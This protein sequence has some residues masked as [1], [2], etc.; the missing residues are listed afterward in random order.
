MS[1]SWITGVCV[2]QNRLEWTVLRRMKESWEISDQGSTPIPESDAPGEGVPLAVLK[3]HLKRFQGKISIALPTD[4]VLLRVALLPTVDAEELRGMAE[5]QTDKFSPFPVESVASGAEVLEAS[6]SSSLVAMAV[7][8]R[9]D[10]DAVGQSFQEAG[11]L[12]D[13]VDVAAL[14]WWWGLQQGEGVPSHGSQIFLRS[15]ADSLDMVL[16]RDGAPLLFR[17]LS[18]LPVE[19]TDA[20]QTEWLEDCTEEIGYSLTSL[21]T[22]WGGAESP[23]LHV[24]HAEGCPVDWADRLQ[25]AL[26]LDAVFVHPLEQLPTVS[27]GV[28]RRLAEPTQSVTMDLAPDAWREADVVRRSR[29]RLLHAATVFLVVWLLSIGIFWTW[30]NLERGQMERLQAEVEAVEGPATEIRRLRSKVREFT[31][32]ADRSHSALESLRI[33]SESLPQ[34]VDL[35][36]FI[37]RKGRALSLRGIADIPDDVYSFIKTLQ[38]TRHFPEVNSEGISTQNTPQG[39]KSQFGAKIVLPGEEEGDS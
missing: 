19:G 34:G 2:Q 15:T 4:R 8:R 27:E 30:L 9:T 17:S 35:T 22:E 12:P 13:V 32:Y 33:I 39:P 3:P 38:E 37:Y 7:V 23:T 10:V 26:Q 5:L 18:L 11:A 16:I 29:R 28:A 20:E 6:D 24:L 25:R 21:E 1:V 31:Q 14:G 36:Q